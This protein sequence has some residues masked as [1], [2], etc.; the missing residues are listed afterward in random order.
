MQRHV[1]GW[2]NRG[3]IEK[4]DKTS[5]QTSDHQTN[6]FRVELLWNRVRFKLFGPDFTTIRVRF[7]IGSGKL[8]GSDFSV[9]SDSIVF[10]EEREPGGGGW[11]LKG[12]HFV[13]GRCGQRTWRWKKVYF[14]T[15]VQAFNALWQGMLK[16]MQWRIILTSSIGCPFP[17]LKWFIL[18]PIFPFKFSVITER[19]DLEQYE[20]RCPEIQAVNSSRFLCW[21]M[22]E[23]PENLT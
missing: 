21:A 7:L 22:T 17:T 6:Y 18:C 3:M 8:I 4:Q 5:K 13:G 19:L 1:L 15:K 16:L 9:K 14:L 2:I 20:D 11:S 12:S 23:K 10:Q